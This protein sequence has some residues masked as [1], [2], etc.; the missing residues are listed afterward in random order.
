MSEG[1]KLFNDE[2]VRVKWDSEIEEYYFSVID[3]IAVLTE[4]KK[5]RDYWY[6]KKESWNMVLICRQIVDS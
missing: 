6:R 4:S 1:I 5:P 3:V 2:K